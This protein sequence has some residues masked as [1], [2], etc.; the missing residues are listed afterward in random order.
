[1][2]FIMTLIMM[3]IMMFPIA[4]TNPSPFTLSPSRKAS[5]SKSP[6]APAPVP[7]PDPAPAAAAPETSSMESPPS[8]GGQ[9]SLGVTNS[10]RLKDV[11]YGMDQ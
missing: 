8:N 10:P 2:M 5:E 6:G 7:A 11:D 9:W 1:M 3:F 4:S